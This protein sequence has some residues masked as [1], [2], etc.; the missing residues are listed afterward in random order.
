MPL[1]DSEGS[2]SAGPELSSNRSRRRA[3]WLTFIFLTIILA[4]ALSVA[5]VGGY[6]FL[7]WIYQMFAGPPG[8]PAA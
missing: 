6:G 1:V 2:P 8:P 7:I 5:V 4:P 3:E